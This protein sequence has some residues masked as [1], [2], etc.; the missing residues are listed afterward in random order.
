MQASPELVHYTI[1]GAQDWPMFQQMLAGMRILVLLL[2]GTIVAGGG[3]MWND[4]KKRIAS[5]RQEDQA[6]CI[7]CKNER[8]EEFGHVWAAIDVVAPRDSAAASAVTAAKGR[9]ASGKK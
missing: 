9:L 6:H 5:Q 3:Y 7:A 8:T 2:W 1:T 4:L